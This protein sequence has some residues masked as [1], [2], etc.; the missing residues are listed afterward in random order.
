MNEKSQ[1]SIA[2][3]LE[4]C[5][6]G[7]DLRR[8]EITDLL[9][10]DPSSLP[11]LMATADRLREERV[12]PT[13]TYVV[14]RNINFTN[15]CVKRC[16]F[17]SFSRDA[18]H[19]EAYFLSLEDIVRRAVEAA[20][21]GATE[22]C[23][24]AGLAPGMPAG[25][26]TEVCRAIRIALPEIH[27]H[28]FSPEEIVYGA[29]L[30]RLPVREFLIQLME[31]GLNTLPGTSA[32]ILEDR[33]RR[34]ISPARISTAQWIEAVTTAHRLGIHTSATIMYGHVENEWDRAGHLLLL[35]SLQRETGGFTEL[36][37]LGF[38]RG[39]SSR[40]RSI[41]G[42]GS[43]PTGL[44][45]LKMH[46]VARLVLGRD[47]PHLQVSWVKEGMKLA[48]VCLAA[49]ANDLGGTLMN[50]RISSSAGASHGEF[51]RPRAFREVIRDA[52]RTPAERSTTY[53]VLRR[54]SEIEQPGDAHPLDSQPLDRFST[55]D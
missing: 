12:G 32:E 1:A 20:D 26:Y 31:A 6:R 40:S 28:A 39:D 46:A 29:G 9:Q 51:M 45:V 52:G 34:E 23:L 48:Q 21:L 37:P 14:N 33:V 2:D 43:G 18:D 5:L 19:P 4:R 47:I 36:V 50:E 25:F 41:P 27:I 55:G 44:E 8:E 22:V 49:G 3:L 15:L 10:A 24:Q 54:F 35:R 7:C 42:R 11:D 38:V 16:R 13:V 30:N 53:R 17:C